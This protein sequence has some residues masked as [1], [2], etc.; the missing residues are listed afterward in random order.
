VALQLARSAFMV[1]AF[2]RSSPM[3]RN[4]AQL[5]AW[6]AIA[7]A[8]W[9]VGGIVH[10]DAR[11]IVWAVAIVLDIGA[12]LHGFRLP[13][14]APT[15]MENWSLAG[16]HLAE[17]C[18]L[19]LMIALGES[20]LRV[21]VTFS[22]Q[23]GSFSVDAAFVAGFVASA[24]LWAIY[25]L[26]TAETG[27]EVITADP[28]RAG[29]LGRAG[30]TYAHAAMVAGVIVEAV[31]VRLVIRHPGDGMS[32]AA[33]VVILGGPVLYVAGLVLF[34]HVLHRGALRPPLA[35]IVV[36]GLLSVVAVAGTDLL[37]LS[38]CATVVLAALAVG[39]GLGLDGLGSPE[40]N[41]AEPR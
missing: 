37:V 21:G 34:K 8:V 25:F 19:V 3:R 30:Y 40:G 14:V 26:R 32:V 7:G 2:D 23:R 15:A 36:L 35:A 39:A 28:V 13:G 38:V 6:S 27:A 22:E 16:G 33:A 9:I 20:V 11:L 4:Y 10:G 41:P 24:A 5:L 1:W 12:P 29:R 31:A 17:R 18:Q